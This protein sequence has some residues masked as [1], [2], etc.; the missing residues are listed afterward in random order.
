MQ[1]GPAA[2]F[3]PSSVM[4]RVTR[5]NFLALGGP[6]ALLLQLAHP[7]V[8]AGVDHHSTFRQNPF[9]PYRR[10]YT[11]GDTM[12][13]IVFGSDAQA[14]R[15]AAHILGIH[16]RVHGK[17]REKAGPV[18]RGSAY[19]AHDPALLTWVMATLYETSVNF[20]GRWAGPLA[21]REK[22][23][24]YNEWCALAGLLGAPRQ[25]MPANSR[26]FDA[27]YRRMLGE[28]LGVGE[29][30]RELSRTILNPPLMPRSVVEFGKLLTTGLL[31]PEVREMYGLPWG[32]WRQAAFDF[33]DSAMGRSIQRWPGVVRYS[34]YWMVAEWR[35]RIESLVS[36]TA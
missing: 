8:A 14:K 16:D 17:T 11:T 31:P 32:P 15:A 1:N 7:K 25:T 20:Y 27:Y 3:S 28:G 9:A 18:P 22:E 30:A 10:L 23:R 6:R 2:P 21:P 33:A 5:E 26:A 4:W 34:P 12:Q 35:G 29:V 36:R 24:Y 19:T 13:K